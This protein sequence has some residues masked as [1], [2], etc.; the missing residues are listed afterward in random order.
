MTKE[1]ITYLYENGFSIDEIRNLEK[2]KATL[3]DSVSKPVESVEA[4]EK[5]EVNT[6]DQV[7]E[8]K[9]N[10]KKTFDSFSEIGKRLDELT[11]MIQNENR[12]KVDIEK[13][14]VYSE[15]D[16]I[17]EFFENP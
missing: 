9:E 5:P 1:E 12:E 10:E 4:S 17:R 13:P 15:A 7:T 8:T 3:N 16:A 6:T 11:K 14:P 2:P